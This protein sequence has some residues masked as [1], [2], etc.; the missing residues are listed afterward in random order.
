MFYSYGGKNAE[1]L[2]ETHY[3][4]SNE[5]HHTASLAYAHETGGVFIGIGTDQNFLL[6]PR[7]RPTHLVM[8]DFDQWAVDTHAI[9]QHL[10]KT[11]ETPREFVNFF[12]PKQVHAKRRELRT[13]GLT[14]AHGA[15]LERVYARYHEE[16][17]KRLREV[18]RHLNRDGTA[19][20]LND[21]VTYDYL[22]SFAITGRYAALRGDLTGERSL[23]SLATTLKALRL[24]VGAVSLSNA[25]QYFKYT[26]SFKRNMR[27]FH[28]SPNALVFRTFRVQGRHYE[29]YLQSFTAFL[30]SLHDGGP[31]HIARLVTRRIPTGHSRIFTLP[32]RVTCL[33]GLCALQTP[34]GELTYAGCCDGATLR[35]CHLET[36]HSLECAPGGQPSCGWSD[37][38]AAYTCNAVGQAPVG[39]AV[40]CP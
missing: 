27:A 21:Q 7:V 17:F 38:Q 23:T 25:E 12:S 15:R 9:Y 28:L 13:S 2:F 16:I 30:E 18:R 10:F 22:R 3:I 36:L 24:Q 32:G 5:R 35:W 40:S 33:T 29:Y 4:T 26:R 1:T 6:I 20:Y 8:V 39:F 11:K 34:C 31:P 14:P 19:G 37:V